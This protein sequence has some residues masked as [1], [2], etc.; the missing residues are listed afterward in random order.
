[1]EEQQSPSRPHQPWGDTGHGDVPNRPEETTGR[2]A[3]EE[4]ILS[5]DE[6]KKIII[7]E[8]IGGLVDP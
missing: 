4:P 1:M 5:L 7:D 6:A 8:F 3:E 2:R